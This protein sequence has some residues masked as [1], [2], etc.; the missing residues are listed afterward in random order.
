[1]FAHICPGLILYLALSGSVSL[2]GLKMALL[3]IYILFVNLVL[4]NITKAFLDLVCK[5]T[6]FGEVLV[7]H[8]LLFLNKVFRSDVNLLIIIGNSGLQLY[9]LINN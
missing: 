9:F 3:M 6:L 5:V 1:M 4:D 2:L 7:H 8:L